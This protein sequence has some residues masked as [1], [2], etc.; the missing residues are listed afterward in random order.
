[1]QPMNYGRQVVYFGMPFEE[2][3][4]RKFQIGTPMWFGKRVWVQG[5]LEETRG[6]CD[7]RNSDLKRSDVPKPFSWILRGSGT[8]PVSRTP[9]LL[10]SPDS[11]R[12]GEQILQV[13]VILR[14]I[15]ENVHGGSL[16]PSEVI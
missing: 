9:H 11:I 16:K 5:K 13:S 2:R 14:P 10:G 8:F 6:F 7:R 4:L 15:P 1:M 12:R 3:S